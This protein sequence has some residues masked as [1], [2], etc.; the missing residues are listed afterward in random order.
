MNTQIITIS[1]FNGIV[2]MLKT[3]LF[4]FWGIY[5]ASIGLSGLEIGTFFA[6]N[7][8]A[9][10]LTILPSGLSND[11]F[12]SKN[13]I[14]ISLILA[15][16]F[17]FGMASTVSFPI[18]LF[19]GALIGISLK[20][21]DSSSDSLFYRAAETENFNK[22]L[23]TF[24]SINYLTIS[25]GTMLTGYIIGLDIAFKN[26]FIAVAIIFLI[27]A[28]LGFFILPKNDTTKFEIIHYKKDIFKK[29]VMIFLLVIILFATHFGVEG[30]SYGLFLKETLNLSSL[31]TG[32]YMG[33][34]MFP[35]AISSLIISKKLKNW[36]A[37]NILLFGLLLSGFGHILMTIKIV[38][39]S[40]L[41]RTIHEIGD[42]AFFFFLY[43]GVS[44][45][46]S[47]ERIGGNTGMI[48][49]VSA[50]GGAVSSAFFGPIGEKF[51]YDIP[52]AVSGGISLLA[53]IV[54]LSFVKYFDHKG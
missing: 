41:F 28:I 18:L 13:L 51:G 23:G 52:I 27:L 26:V 37:K 32:L 33:L 30:T 36:K 14:S 4:F 31:Q 47:M 48:N 45:I 24:Q 15:A 39:V 21:Y 6:V 54:V 20:I 8:F 19:L 3:S 7:S 1:T 40:F 29:D 10:I 53:V 2:R 5:F 44:K 43:Y 35:M 46:F 12:K 17:Y 11:R 16:I 50:I 49:F 25:L 38:E 22:H 34:A 9:S 42:S